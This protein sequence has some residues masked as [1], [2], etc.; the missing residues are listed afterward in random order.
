MRQTFAN[1]LAIVI[2]ILIVIL[3]A[4]IALIQM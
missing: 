3:S 1:H 2:G 4:M